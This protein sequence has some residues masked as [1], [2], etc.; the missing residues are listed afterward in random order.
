MR[1]MVTV[2]VPSATKKT[3]LESTVSVKCYKELEADISH[4]CSD[5]SYAN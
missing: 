3:G 2:C 5:I 4:E 1:Y